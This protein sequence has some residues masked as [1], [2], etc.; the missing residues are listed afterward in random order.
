MQFRANMLKKH[1]VKPLVLPSVRANVLTIKITAVLKLEGEKILQDSNVKSVLI[2]EIFEY[3]IMS[4]WSLCLKSRTSKM[5]ERVSHYFLFVVV[6]LN[7][8]IF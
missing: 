8:I 7:N 1:H 2:H 4:V 5:A 3:G 6:F